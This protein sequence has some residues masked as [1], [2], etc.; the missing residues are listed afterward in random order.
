M[1]FNESDACSSAPI[2]VLGFVVL[3]LFAE[4]LHAISAHAERA[5][6]EECCGILLGQIDR[7]SLTDDRVVITIWELPNA[8]DAD[9]EAQLSEM[10]VSDKADGAASGATKARR[11]WIAPQDMFKA[12]QFARDRQM[13][14]IGIYHSHPNHP[15]VPS[16][17]DRIWA[18]P[19]YS[20]VIASVQKG[21]TEA[22]Q[23]WMLDTDHQFQSEAIVTMSPWSD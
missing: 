2:N 13:A 10:A 9:A 15:A 4:D 23:S 22:I 5:Y 1:V 17:C 6:P 3:C 14:I 20:Y 11:Y 18:W 8:W 12:Q 16:E 21:H 19:D 7:Q